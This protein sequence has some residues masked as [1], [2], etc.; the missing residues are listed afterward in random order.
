MTE[1][2]KKRNMSNL[3]PATHPKSVAQLLQLCLT[4]QPYG[5]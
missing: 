2:K 5:L 4:V 3:N 1:L